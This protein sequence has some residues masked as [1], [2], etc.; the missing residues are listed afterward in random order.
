MTGPDVLDRLMARWDKRNH[1]ATTTERRA[2]EVV[3]GRILVEIQSVGVT[4][5]GPFEKVEER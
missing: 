3:L 5:A 2:H 4:F 1:G